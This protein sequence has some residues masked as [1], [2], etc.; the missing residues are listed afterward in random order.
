MKTE[1][2]VGTQGW[3][4]LDVE[5]L[6]E[7]ESWRVVG[8]HQVRGRLQEIWKRP[9]TRKGHFQIGDCQLQCRRTE[10]IA[11]SILSTSLR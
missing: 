9:Y 2:D 10:G 7:S 5:Q 6:L 1:I 8:R 3:Q 4:D 11:V